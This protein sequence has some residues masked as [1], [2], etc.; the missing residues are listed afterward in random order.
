MHCFKPLKHLDPVNAWKA[1]TVF[2]METS[3]I[4]SSQ[5][6]LTAFVAKAYLQCNQ[7]STLD[8]NHASG[9]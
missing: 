2:N 7:S 9:W 8:R 5:K 3:A 4:H 6:A 1:P